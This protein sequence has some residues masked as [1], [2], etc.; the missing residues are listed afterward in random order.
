MRHRVLVAMAAALLPLTA[1]TAATAKA[2][3][4][5]CNLITD[6][7]DDAYL[8]STSATTVALPELDVQSVDLA[9][10]ARTVVVVMRLGSTK[11]AAQQ[12][13]TGGGTWSVTYHV[14]GVVV[15][16]DYTMAPGA[17]G[18]TFT[19]TGSIS[20]DGRASTAVPVT[21]DVSGTM[22]RWTMPRSAL[23]ELAKRRGIFSALF[24]QANAGGLAHDYAPDDGR[25]APATYLD[26]SASC[27][28]AA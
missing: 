23:T 20:R 24:A 14:W 11:F 17:G 28:K 16:L 12:L 27:V 1:A 8:L 9:S 26:R 19:A 6:R 10:G 13:L 25:A 15:T 5:A 3:K 2:P 21:A 4:A 18:P 7:H 22:L